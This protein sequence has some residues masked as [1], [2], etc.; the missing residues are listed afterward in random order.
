MAGETGNGTKTLDRSPS[1]DE[2]TLAVTPSQSSFQAGGKYPM[3]QK[4][5]RAFFDYWAELREGRLAPLRSEIE[6][7]KIG[8]LL[9]YVFILERSDLETAR[10]RLAGTAL[11]RDYRMEFRGTNM[12]LMWQGED[13]DTMSRLLE[14]VT[15]SGTVTLVDYTSETSEG[16]QVS[17]ELLLTPLAREEGAVDRVFGVVVPTQRPYWLGEKLFAR[18]WID[19]VR[20]VGANDDMPVAFSAASAN[21]DW[22]DSERTHLRLVKG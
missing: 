17:F 4:V 2:G 5:T 11:C 21:D 10:F 3:A 9:P 7:G 12:L 15:E 20:L 8:R 6:P 18:Q 19:R 13:R 1:Q 14:R 22:P 16:A